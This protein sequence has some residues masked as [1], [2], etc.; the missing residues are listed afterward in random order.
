MNTS[1]GVQ[2]EAREAWIEHYQGQLRITQER[3]NDL[4][5]KQVKLNQ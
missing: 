2:F 4:E 5:V 3:L 1:G